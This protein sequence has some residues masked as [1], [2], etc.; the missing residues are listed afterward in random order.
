MAETICRA[1]RDGALE[2]EYAPALTIKDTLSTPFGFH[3]FTHF[4]CNLSSNILSAKSQSQCLVLVAFSKSPSFYYDLLKSRGI[5]IQT[6]KNW[7]RI[8]DCY[9]DPLGWKDGDSMELV[10]NAIEKVCKNVKDLDKLLSSIL[11][12]GKGV[13]GQGKVRFSVAVDSVSGMLRHASVSSVASLINNLRSHG[14]VSC[15]FWLIHSDLH[16]VRTT[17]VLEYMSSMVA[18][19]EP[20]VAIGEKGSSENIF[21]LEQN[22]GK[23]KFNVRLKRRNGRVKAMSE[24]FH[25]ERPGIKFMVISSGSG[26]VN[27]TLVPKV[28]F[29]LQLSEKELADRE[30]V[31]LPFEHQG[32]GKD[33]EIYD[34]R[35]SLSLGQNDLATPVLTNEKL[36]AKTDQ[37]KG[38]IHYLRDSDDEHPDSDED[39]DDDLDI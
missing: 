6:S 10:P 1:L 17:A 35:R 5:D 9:S 29:N 21:S 34:G 33:V 7:L 8:L 14:Q 39:P 18:S 11:E 32:N 37:G 13:V 38:E 19:L 20:I 30:N 25:V 36:H 23:G 27:K 16:E 26:V 31:V 28:Q 3:T 12:L 4:L 24:E 15:V 2:G 22:S